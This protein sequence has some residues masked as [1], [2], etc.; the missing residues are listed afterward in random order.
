MEL[1]EFKKKAIKTSFMIDKLRADAQEAKLD[2]DKQVVTFKTACTT[3]NKFVDSCKPMVAEIEK[4]GDEVRT[5]CSRSIDTM[6]QL[7]GARKSAENKV[8]STVED[9]DKILADTKSTLSVIDSDIKSFKDSWIEKVKLDSSSF[10]QII[11]QAI[12]E[13]EK[14]RQSSSTQLNLASRPICSKLSSSLR[15]RLCISSLGRI[16]RLGQT[17]ASHHRV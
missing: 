2:L 6:T 10:H 9:M 17:S 11:T 14:T 4:K 15:K 7:L 13:S 1:A 16:W 5:H 12:L 8:T 3:V